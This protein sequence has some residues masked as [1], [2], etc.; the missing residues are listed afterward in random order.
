MVSPELASTQ[1]IGAS[2][3]LGGGE[4]SPT[5]Q[6]MGALCCASGDLAGSTETAHVTRL[7]YVRNAPVSRGVNA[8][9]APSA[10]CLARL[11]SKV[12]LKRNAESWNA[13]SWRIRPIRR[14]LTGLSTWRS[15]T[16]SRLKPLSFAARKETSTR[17]LLVDQSARRLPDPL[18]RF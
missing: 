15:K 18:A 6:P 17:N 8:G 9:S 14:P 13:C 2:Y 7:R 5:G 10:Q 12:M 16:G 11:Q 3:S 1:I 4:T